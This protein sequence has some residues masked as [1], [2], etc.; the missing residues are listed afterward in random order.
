MA[1]ENENT[2]KAGRALYRRKYANHITLERALFDWVC[3]MRNSS[4]CISGNLI[5]SKAFHLSK[6]SNEC[7]PASKEITTLF[8]E[9]CLDNFKKRFCLRAFKVHRQT[10]DVHKNDMVVQ[11]QHIWQ[12]MH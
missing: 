8:T 2:G 7:L 5:S 12:C 10:G 3:N 9:G 4:C 1:E 11:R 6:V